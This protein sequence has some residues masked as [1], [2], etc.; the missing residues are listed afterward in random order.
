MATIDESLALIGRGAE[1]ILKLEQL[2]A[3]LTSGVPLRVKAGF[4]PTAPDLHLGHTVLLNKMRQFQELGHQVIFLIGDFTG[5]IGDP[6]GKNVTRKPLSREDVLANARTYEEQVFKILDRTRT[7]VRFNSEWFGQMSAADMIKLSAQHTVARM[8]ERDDFAKRFAGQQPIAIH[9]FLYPLVQGYDSVALKADVEL[10]GT[11]QTFNLLMGRGLQEHY[12]QAPQVVLTMPLL[13]G[14]D[15]VAKMSKSLGN[16]IG[17]N[18]PAIDIVTKTM[19]IG[20][21]LTWRWI[22]LLSFDISVAEAARFK[23]D[24]A[25][26]NLHPRDVKLRL[27]RELATRFHDAATAEQAIAGWHAVVTGQGDTSVLPLQQVSVPAEGLRIASLL[28][29]A[30]LTPSNSEATR[31]LKERAVKIDGEVV[32]DLARQFGPGFEGVIQVGKRNF[33]RVALVTS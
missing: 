12:G 11:D 10:G 1:E 29:A 27:A 6:S 21:T 25:A 15:G 22:D 13:E 14:L 20:D 2:E 16:Y 8:L 5:M 30:G 9:E 4:D 19:K 23:E 33:A 24:V 7:E 3:R 32:D 31:K 26:G 18:E 28:T 17:I